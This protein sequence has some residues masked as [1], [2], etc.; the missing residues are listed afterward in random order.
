MLRSIEKPDSLFE[1]SVHERSISLCELGVAERPEGSSGTTVTVTLEVMFSA[2][3]T[4]TT[5]KNIP[6]TMTSAVLARMA[7]RS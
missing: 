7:G 5:E 2:R 3:A 4:K 1:L 6:K